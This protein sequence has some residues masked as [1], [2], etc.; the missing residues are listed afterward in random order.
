MLYSLSRQNMPSSFNRW[1]ELTLPNA[2]HLLGI[3]VIALVVNRLLRARRIGNHRQWGDSHGEQPQPR[4]VAGIRGR[5]ARTGKSGRENIA[6]AGNRCGRVAGRPGMV[7]SAGRRA[8]DP[9][10]AEL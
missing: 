9:W 5:L 3:L 7:A 8:A 6:G 4:L 1:V 10:R 2:L